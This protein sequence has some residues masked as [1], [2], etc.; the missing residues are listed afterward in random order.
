M[1]MW[2]RLF[3]LPATAAV[4]WFASL[5]QAGIEIARDGKSAY[6]IVV[7]DDADEVAKY[8]ARELQDHLKQVMSAELPI[9][10]ESSLAGGDAPKI[11]VGD[12]KV[13]RRLLPQLDSKSLGSDG[14][15]MKTAG[16]DLIL[17]GGR[18]RGVLYA[19]DTFLEDS[20]G[21]RWWT[22][23]E[24]T[25]PTKPTLTIDALDVTYVPKFRY[26]EVFNLDVMHNSRA[27]FASRLKLNGQH[28][29]IPPEMGGHY[30][31]LGW[32][33]TS[34]HLVP[35]N[36]YFGAH[37]EWFAML[38]G[39]RQAGSQLCLT[40]REMQKVLIAKALDL[41]RRN[42]VAGM[43]SISQNDTHGP[44]QCP[45]CA[46][47]VKEEGSES[48]PWIR[49]CNTVAA[50]INKEYP[51]F[52]V[53]TL[54]YQYTRKP[55]KLTKPSKNVIVRLC[56]IEAD[57]SH[58]LAGE[59]NQS[60]GDDLRGW[61]AI[62]PNL[63][64]WNYVTNFADYL[65]PHPNMTPFAADLRFFAD[66]NV[67]GVFEQGDYSNDRAG[68]FLPL[69]TWLLAK[70]LWDPSRDQAKLTE[71]FL[72]GYYGAAGPH[73]A[74]Y[75]AIVNAPAEKAN[76]RMGCYN[77]RTDFL[78]NGAIAA[79]TKH[80]DDASRAV[81][82]DA[83]LERRVRRERLA[84]D[85]VR[86]L[87]YD[88]RK[89]VERLE[90]PEAARDE[91]TAKASEWASAAR[92]SGVRNFSEM[93]G[94]DAYVTTLAARASQFIPP[95]I[96]PRGAKLP[97]GQFDLQ[98]DQFH[99]HNPGTD[100]ALVDD[101]KASN[102]R[103]ARMPAASSQWAVQLHMSDKTRFIG[104][105]PWECFVLARVEMNDAASDKK[106]RAFLYGLHDTTK[107]AIVART[108]VD[109]DL[110]ADGEYHAYGITVDEFHPGEYI[111]VSPPASNAK[112][113]AVYVDRIFIR[114][115]QQQP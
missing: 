111:W 72:N 88:F 47:V 91:Y 68:D 8:A 83:E 11:L 15:V 89:A 70:L 55:P 73:L 79:A 37:P 74:K 61:K 36:T 38:N 31:L 44:C 60:F 78:S 108:P 98:E 48:G 101:D 58:P 25:I 2:V 59:S 97:D 102:K 67:I 75:L 23:T 30:S 105:G 3:V 71:E 4:V 7:A 41:A 95:A 65:I 32:C 52:L 62:A 84:I 45:D 106:G 87:R 107:N 90:T 1:R 43:I 115:Q 112:V 81:S 100:A 24:S 5:A 51:D 18:P 20:V 40:N 42:P 22:S 114:K 82:G 56:S 92:A 57:F 86:L 103:A 63:F 10:G 33:H 6:V 94:I 110:A 14:I 13:T 66:H 9:V 80:F 39:K 19:V 93:Q 27:A 85:H 17:T 28:Q 96:P 53:E 26:R 69:R 104:K 49:L 35:P 34:F 29:A 21:V 99:L 113:K 46:T 64:I 16:D 12:T 76:F 109:L 77:T 50:E 54:A